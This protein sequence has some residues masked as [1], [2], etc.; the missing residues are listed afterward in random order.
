MMSLAAPPPP[1]Q[2]AGAPPLGA[3]GYPQATGLGGGYAPQYGV[4]G[5]GGAY[6]GGLPGSYPAS[7]AAPLSSGNPV[8]DMETFQ[9]MSALDAEALRRIF[10]KFQEV[11]RVRLLFE[12]LRLAS[13]ASRL[14]CQERTGMVDVNEFCRLLRVE[15]SSFVERLF[16]MFDT[17][18]GGLIDL[19]EF[20]VG[21][22]VA[23]A[24]RR[25]QLCSPVS[26]RAGQRERRCARG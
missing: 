13:H 7:T 11:D 6:P 8:Q 2:Q 24:C 21:A 12:R 9:R 16:S 14:L 4:G 23:A 25:L 26:R 18:R 22:A 3:P 1:P 20:I 19:K 17:D 10:R 15:R 5:P